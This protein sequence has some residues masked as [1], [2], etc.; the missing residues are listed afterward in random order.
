MQRCSPRDCSLGLK[1]AHEFCRLGLGTC[2]TGLEGSVSAVF[3]T[4]L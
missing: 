3:K 1:I 4:N 2:G